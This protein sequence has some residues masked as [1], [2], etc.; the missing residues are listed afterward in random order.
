MAL[1]RFNAGGK[2]Q[3]AQLMRFCKDIQIDLCGSIFDPLTVKWEFGS[4]VLVGVPYERFSHLVRPGRG[5]YRYYIHFYATTCRSGMIYDFSTCEKAKEARNEKLRTKTS[6]FVSGVRLA[7]ILSP[8]I[9]KSP[10][11]EMGISLWVCSILCLKVSGFH[12][13]VSSPGA[14]WWTEAGNQRGL[15]SLRYWWLRLVV[16]PGFLGKWEAM[17]FPIRLHELFDADESSNLLR[18]H[19]GFSYYMIVRTTPQLNRATKYVL[20]VTWSQKNLKVCFF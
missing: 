11:T 2:K 13:E 16:G 8:G 3:K 4:F 7:A 10:P 19:N 18:R 17:M 20:T 14:D 5:I 1:R 9:F 15:W 6:C 12:H